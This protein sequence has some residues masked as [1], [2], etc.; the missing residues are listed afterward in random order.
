MNKK[1]FHILCLT[2]LVL[3]IFVILWGA[4]VRF[5]H[6][7][8]GCGREWPL[9]QNSFIPKAAEDGI[10]KN[11]SEKTW[12]EFTHRVSSALFGLIVLALFILSFKVFPKKHLSQIFSSSALFFTVVEALIGALLVVKGLTGENSSLM[13]AL[14]LNFHLMNSLFLMASLALCL[15]SSFGIFKI[16]SKKTI[17]FSLAFIFIALLGSLSSLSNTLFPSVSLLEGLMSDWNAHSHWLVRL[18]WVHPLAAF[19]LVSS[20][21]FWSF[22]SG[23][24]QKLEFSRKNFFLAAVFLS[25][26]TG[27]VTLISLSPLALKLIHIFMAY[28]VWLLVL[29][30]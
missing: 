12:I 4:F 5:S 2:A 23:F 3:G 26:L 18:R 29:F 20:F 9:C 13:R 10:S 7:G 30:L 19:L 1:H 6:S 17:Y 11:I 28:L 8:D 21:L 16:F 15:K 24:F 22:Y 27:I 25:F 14:V